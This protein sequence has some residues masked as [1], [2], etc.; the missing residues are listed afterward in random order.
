MNT[1]TSQLAKPSVSDYLAEER[2]FLAWIRTGLSLMGFGFVV[3]RFG[4]FLQEIDLAQHN[5]ALPSHQF[6][7]WFGIVL[8]LS[9]VI[10]NV[11]AA[12][13]H[14]QFGTNYESAELEFHRSAKRFAVAA[15]FL[16]LIGLAMAA[17]LALLHD[18]APAAATQSSAEQSNSAN[19]KEPLMSPQPQTDYGIVSKPSAHSVDET[20]TKLKSILESKGVTIFALV[21]HSGEA[22]KAG[23]TMPNTKLLIFG[24]PKGGTPIMLAAPTSAID[25][26]LKILV[27]QDAQSKVWV[28]YNSL[29]Y[30]RERHGI[31]QDLLPNLAVVEA[32]AAAGAS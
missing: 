23:L 15:L 25:L 27:W 31:P 1:P 4:L 11:Y 22:A 12:R 28:S 16:A 29:P 20:V 30:L 17:Y 14:A 26:P 3:A 5:R 9:G 13:R 18:S 8:I 24:N 32:L 7:L 21:D 6:S 2:T 19:A 10:V